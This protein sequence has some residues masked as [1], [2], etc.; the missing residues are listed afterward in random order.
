MAVICARCG[1]PLGDGD[2][3][4][5][6]CGAPAEGEKLRLIPVDRNQE[7]EKYIRV[8]EN[9][10]EDTRLMPR[11][12][13]SSGNGYK[14]VSEQKQAK[15]KGAAGSYARAQEGR[16]RRH[17][18]KQPSYEQ[19][20]AYGQNTSGRQFSGQEGGQPFPPSS[21][22]RKSSGFRGI[23]ALLL[24]IALLLGW[25]GYMMYAAGRP[26]PAKENVQQ[27]QPTPQAQVKVE[28]PARE[29]KKL[30][31]VAAQAEETKP[32]PTAEEL[33]RMAYAQ[34]AIALL[35]ADERELAELAAAVNEGR[36]SRKDLQVWAKKAG[37]IMQSRRNELHQEFSIDKSEE[38]RW[39]AEALF[40]WQMQRADCIYQGLTGHTEKYGE[41]GKIYDKFQERYARFKE[42][43][44]H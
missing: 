3:M 22:R 23:K 13:V 1:A 11:E 43:F 26:E 36:M 28:E 18:S 14:T 44:S 2:K 16:V 19:Q 15:N 25:N 20:P 40:Y 12:A 17:K 6:Q 29:P 31:P 27:Q 37:K 33:Q 32:Q 42:K 5:R 10:L 24:L 7:E 38:L 4:C 9:N 30:Q 41:G 21:Q 35:D 34:K 39:E 8:E